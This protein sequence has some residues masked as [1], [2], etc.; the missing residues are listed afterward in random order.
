VGE[1][2]FVDLTVLLEEDTVPVG[3]CNVLAITVGCVD[4]N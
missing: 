2:I 4:G 1:N 3:I